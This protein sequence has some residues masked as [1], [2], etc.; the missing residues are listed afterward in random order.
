MGSFSLS[1]TSFPYPETPSRIDLK[2][3]VDAV[4]AGDQIGWAPPYE[5]R[6]PSPSLARLIASAPS[7][8]VFY[9]GGLPPR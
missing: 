9:L 8:S 3:E 6:F 2:Q 5:R 4:P 1:T 7:L